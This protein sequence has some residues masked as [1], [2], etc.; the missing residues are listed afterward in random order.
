MLR[1]PPTFSHLF[2]S[3][4]DVSQEPSRT[5][6]LHLAHCSLL[7]HASEHR[8]ASASHSSEETRTF[9]F[10]IFIFY[11]NSS[12]PDWS[13]GDASVAVALI[14][15][16]QKVPFVIQVHGRVTLFPIK[17]VL[18]ECLMTEHGVSPASETANEAGRLRQTHLPACRRARPGRGEALPPGSPQ[19]RRSPRRLRKVSF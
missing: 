15:H 7:S 11:P 12:F 5:T 10:L 9:F 18:N 1:P 16:A 14:F 17:M 13:D 2:S 3:V 4:R 19:M 6:A 8:A